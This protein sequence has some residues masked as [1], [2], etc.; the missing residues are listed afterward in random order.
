MGTRKG[1]EAASTSEKIS[2]LKALCPVQEWS[3]AV[4]PICPFRSVAGYVDT[5]APQHTR[6]EIS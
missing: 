1:L 3:T 2:T 4:T 6:Q 5:W